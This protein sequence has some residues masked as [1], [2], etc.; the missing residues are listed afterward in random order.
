MDIFLEIGQK[1]V[2]AGAIDWPGWSR[3]GR[4]EA[5]AIANL[6]DHG[7][8][9]GR[10]ITLAGLDF[11]APADTTA[12]TIVERLPGGSGT[13]FGAPTA[14]LAADERPFDKAELD[15]SRAILEAVWQAFDAAAESAVGVALRKGPRGGGRDLDKIVAHVRESDAAYLPLLGR[16][17]PKGIADPAE[18]H[19]LIRREMLDAL[20]AA[21]QGELPERG[22]R[23]GQLWRPRFFV[24]YVAWHTLDHAWEIEDRAIWNAG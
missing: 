21:T 10:A 18:E 7:P 6:L 22:P 4:D 23:G 20:D 15:R 12:L 3:S 13:D 1:R 11:T 5:A 24:R 2:F 16:K 19:A 17:R 8:R 14:R 9:Y